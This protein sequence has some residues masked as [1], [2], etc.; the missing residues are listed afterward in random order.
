VTQGAS[1]SPDLSVTVGA[2]VGGTIP[3]MRSFVIA[4]AFV[5][6]IALV[7]V[8]PAH[9]VGGGD[10]KDEPRV[11][12]DLRY[13]SVDGVD[14]NLLSLDLYL[15]ATGGDCPEAPLVVGVHGGGWH[16]GDKARFTG[17]KASVFNEQGWAFASVNYR[18]TDPAVT[19]AVRYPTHN[20]DVATAVGRLVDHARRYDLDPDRLALLGHSAGAGIVAAV[21]TDER[22]LEAQGLSLGAISCSVPIDTEGFDVSARIG[23]GGRAA[24]LYRSVFGNDP[25]VWPEASPLTHVQA[26]K[27]IPSTLL[28]R[29]GN[30]SRQAQLD[31]FAAALR[32]ADVDVEV[33]DAT[34]LS[35]GDVNTRI[36]EPGDDVMTPAVTGFLD[37]CFTSPR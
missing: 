26:G 11:V 6:G 37:G 9:A 4:A 21:T 19:P 31:E 2:Q 30:A 29:R 32:D 24:L 23:S 16:R 18:L 25:A 8:A 15:P 1:R 7:P 17:D 3:G 14:A 28:V 34:G 27:G 20:E 35:H 22:Y 5:I 10:C 36:G 33:I 13:A 12:R